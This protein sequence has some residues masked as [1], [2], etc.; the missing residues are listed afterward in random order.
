MERIASLFLELSFLALCG[1]LYYQWQKK[2]ILHGPRNW[3]ASK[4]MQLHQL[5]MQDT[6]ENLFAD[7]PGF[8]A[9]LEK[10]LKMDDPHLNDAFLQEWSGKQ[11]PGEVLEILDECKE[12]A[13]QSHP[14]TR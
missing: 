12:W 2:R 10:L 6:G 4:L 7:L 5:A 14:M 8:I 3:R 9:G 1:W 13:F 11:L